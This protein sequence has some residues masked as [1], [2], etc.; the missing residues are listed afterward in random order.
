MEVESPIQTLEDFERYTP[1]IRRAPGRYASI[2]K[3][4]RDF[5]GN[6]AVIVHLNDVFSIP[7]SLMGYENLLMAIAAEPG[8]GLARW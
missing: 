1:R 5:G 3:T 8:A 2:E 6:K 7:R 4:V